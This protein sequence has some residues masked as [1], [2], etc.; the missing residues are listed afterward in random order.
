MTL[1]FLARCI[2]KRRISPLEVG[3]VI[4]VTDLAPLDDCMRDML[5]IV[6]WQNRELGVPLVQLEPV[7]VDADTAEAVGDWHY[8]LVRGNELG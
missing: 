3:E 2:Q 6:A 1:P 5:V 8:W 4:E 7:N